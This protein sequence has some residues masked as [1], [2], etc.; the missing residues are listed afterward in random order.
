MGSGPESPAA[1]VVRDDAGSGEAPFESIGIVGL[2]LMGGGLAR[3]IRARWPEIRLQATS[4]EPGGVAAALEDGVIDLAASGAE[5]AVRGVQLVVLATPLASALELIPTLAEFAPGAGMTDVVSLKVPMMTAAE[6][7][8]IGSRFVGAHPMT[9]SERS[10]WAA[11]TDDM[12]RGARVWLTRGN[13]SRELAARV[14]ALWSGIGAEPE[15]VDDATHDETMR[16][17]SHLP[18]LASS[19]LAE[20]LRKRAIDRNQLGPGGR[21]LTRLAGSSPELWGD[22]LAV[23][24]EAGARIARMLARE[25]DAIADLIGAGDSEAL[26]TLLAEGRRWKEGLE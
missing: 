19:A 18:Q 16:W 24:P 11:A 17:V 20:V 23:D 12:Y 2:G 7:A 15:W 4:L 1:H 9:G 10:G 5:S 3:A 8:G 13:A 6:A 14:E 22:L 21:A 26:R 25:L